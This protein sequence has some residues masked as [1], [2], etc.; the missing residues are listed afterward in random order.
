M[1]PVSDS[2]LDAVVIGGGHNGL[3]AAAYLAGAGR[4][5]RVLE[6]A[7]SLGGAARS[8]EVF[9]GRPARL[10]K[11]AYLVSLLPQLIVDELGLDLSLRRRVVSSY[12]PVG[13]GGI[14]VDDADPDATR[15]SLG[16][17]AG[18]WDDLHELTTSVAERVFPTLTEPLRDA[19]A[20]RRH[21]GDDGAWRDLFERPL[22]ELL[23]R[24]F[25]DDTVRG[26]VLTD[27]L[28]G[29][30][31]H[32]HDLLANR[33]FLYH[34]IGRGTGHWDVPV[35]GMGTVTDQL[36]AAAAARGAELL[37]GQDVVA[38]DHRRRRGHGHHRRRAHRRGPARC[39]ATPPPPCSAGCSA[40]RWTPARRRP[41]QGQHAAVAA[42]GAARRG[43]CA[44]SG[45][46]PARSTSTRATSSSRRPTGRRPTAGCPMSRPARSTATR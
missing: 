32:A 39:C 42:A 25:V 46:S 35:G 33:C 11:Y 45:P 23:E 21:V 13:D 12:T 30:F 28:I 6:R 17:D 36:A 14:L 4:S 43:R 10:S 16:A 38:L 34:V 40:S 18:A 20:F 24:C 19:D 37:T 8:D 31:T 41:G 3:V 2:V 22:G 44:P 29:T 9:P 1:P 27:A 7:G 15:A 26:I 5:V